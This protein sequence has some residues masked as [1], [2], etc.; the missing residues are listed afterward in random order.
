[1]NIDLIIQNIMSPPILFFFLGM[2]SVLVKSDLDIPAPL[3]KF[4][5]LYLL[6]DIGFHGG[7]ELHESGF[8]W[9]LIGIL[10]SCV[11]M[12]AVVPVY[13]FFI[14]R[15]RFGAADAAAIAATFGS[16]SAV[17]FITAA[18]FLTNINVSYGGYMVAGMALMESPAIIIGVALF[19]LFNKKE[20]KAVSTRMAKYQKHS[21]WGHILQDAFFNGSVILLIGSLVVG[22]ATGEKGWQAFLPFDLLFKG[23]L[24]FYLLDNGILAA[25]RLKSLQGSFGFLLAFSILM[26][27]LNAGV[28]IL[29]GKAIGMSNGDALLFTV[30]C[31]SASYIAVPA[32]VR[33]AIP[34]SNPAFTVPVALGIVFPFN[35]IVGIPLYYYVIT[36]WSFI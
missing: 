24:C 34:E 26:P 12:A 17:T 3:A 27:L 23:I 21:K 19:T 1:M 20:E 30:L 5:S 16:V 35:V 18:S 4:F 31:A 22:M 28:G 15:K 33:L 25:K 14:L 2:I 10:A 36:L 32:A 8:S 7:H 29:I 11:M 6:M 13:A 9:D